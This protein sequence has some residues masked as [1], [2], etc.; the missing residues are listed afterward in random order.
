ML[1]FL[2]FLAYKGENGI[3]AR[4]ETLNGCLDGQIDSDAQEDGTGDGLSDFWELREGW[5]VTLEGEE[6]YRAFSSP[7]HLDLD[8]DGLADDLE[9]SWGT[10]PN[11]ADTDGDG[12]NDNVDPYPLDRSL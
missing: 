4:E 6:P 2:P 11:R 7:A 1:I 9:L 10:D 5:M 8:G 12:K 3:S